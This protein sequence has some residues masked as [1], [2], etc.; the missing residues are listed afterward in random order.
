MT[1]ETYLDEVFVWIWLPG[2]T[3]PVVAGRLATS[4]AGLVFN[5]GKSYLES[6]DAIPIYE[7]ELP[8]RSG[9]LPLASGFK[10]PGCLRAA[11]PDSWGRR[12]IL[13]RRFGRRGVDLDTG[14]LDELRYLLESGSDRIG[15]L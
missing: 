1:S 10:R 5:Y 3:T 13:H 9:V 7:P 15:A 14:E 2:A 6:K 8:L 12:V 4:A 11:R